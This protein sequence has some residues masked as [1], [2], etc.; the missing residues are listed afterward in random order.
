MYHNAHTSG[1]RGEVAMETVVKI[2]KYRTLEPKNAEFFTTDSS[3]NVKFT[4]DDLAKSGLTPEDMDIYPTSVVNL[5]DGAV[6]GYQ[7][8]YYDLKG[9]ILKTSDNYLTM[10]RTKFDYPIGVKGP[11]YLG[12]STEALAKVQL[13]SSIPYI[14]PQ[15]HALNGTELICAEGEKK[16]ASI[17]KLLQLP[18]FGIGGCQMWRDPDGSGRPHPWILELLRNRSADTLIIVPDGDIAR[19]DISTAYGT[20]ARALEY[21]GFTVHITYPPGK[22]DDLLVQ[23]GSDRIAN[24]AS[25]PKRS[26]QDLVQSPKS[27]ITR[28]SLAFKADAKGNPSVH[29]HTSNI[30]RLM[31]EH[32]AFPKVWLNEDNNTIM[33][34]DD[35]NVPN[36]TDMD[37][38][39]YFQY[40]LGFEKVTDRIIHNCVLSLARTN[41]KSP[42]L[43]YIKGLDWDGKL[44]LDNWLTEY[45]GVEQNSYTSEV[46]SKWLVSACARMDKPGTKIDWMM[47]TIGKQGTGKTSM[48]KIFFGENYH[49]LY[50]EQNDKDLHMLLH[51]HL[52]IGFDELDSFGKRESSNL[53]AMITRSTD[54]FRPPY[55]VSV[56]TFPRRFTLYGCGNKY[57]FLQHDGSGYRRYAV[58][59]ITRSLDFGRLESDRSQI[60]A[61]AWYRYQ[62]GG[63]KYWEV[64]GASEQA[65]RY[66]VPDALGEKVTGWI[67]GEKS[68]KQSSMISNGVLYF[69]IGQLLSGIEEPDHKSKEIAGMIRSIPG[70]EFPK[71]AITGPL[72]GPVKKRYYKVALE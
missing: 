38:A 55:G 53:K 13:P 26:A 58:V 61:E 37:L 12:P 42:F 32:P 66:T 71:Y 59:E 33:L 46:G 47:I 50:G 41:K 14:P 9:Q 17:V 25:I 52:C 24:W 43:E 2:R 10:Y 65:E 34:D 11:K 57:E 70:I 20:F 51:S 4:I 63:V 48:P 29:Q 54:A 62:T 64:S 72:G 69:T 45:W 56:E 28:Y 67:E 6:A 30:M 60:W 22:I 35:L 19:Y 3:K 5:A 31:G 27:L 21:E 16:T 36:K 40:N 8:P 49:P 15:I 23:W 68:K 39:N 44:R 1:P 7:I 18:T